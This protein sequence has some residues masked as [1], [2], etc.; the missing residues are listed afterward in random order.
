MRPR[1]LSILAVGL[2]FARTRKVPMV[3]GLA[4]TVGIL[5]ACFGTL[6]VGAPSASPRGT[7][8]PLVR[9][10]SVA[11]GMLP[12]LVL[13]SQ[14]AE[15][16]AAAGRALRRLETWVLVLTFMAAGLLMTA[17]C[18]VST[19][20]EAVPTTVRSLVAWFGLALISGRVLGWRFCW[21]VPCLMLSV[22][23]YWGYDSPTN[24]YHWWEFTAVRSDSLPAGLLSVGF[25]AA[26]AAMYWFT[27][28]RVA[29][30]RQRIALGASGV[31]PVSRK[32]GS[33]SRPSTVPPKRRGRPPGVVRQ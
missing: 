10:S 14:I 33:R 5:V 13:T 2:V 17:G 8:I 20:S 31:D 12:V 6:A 9:L 7:T 1:S 27:P 32:R 4:V 3:L 18:L 23:I 21:L 22:L 19:G 28:W 25:L 29:A 11:P 30:L 24:A 26:G 15:L 16:E